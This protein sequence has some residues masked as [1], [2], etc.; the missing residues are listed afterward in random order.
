MKKIKK[1]S[2]MRYFMMVMA[3]ATV[4]M[5]S[6][7]SFAVI[8]GTMVTG[9]TDLEVAANGTIVLKDAGGFI[10][11]N[12]MGPAGQKYAVVP[13]GA[14]QKSVL[15]MMYLSKVTNKEI[16]C[17]VDRESSNGFCNVN[18]CYLED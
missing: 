5:T 18:Y 3:I 11:S 9:I 17:R 1:L 4:V 7:S 2:S 16:T 15:A 14:G 10:H 6:A 13:E 12:C 8:E